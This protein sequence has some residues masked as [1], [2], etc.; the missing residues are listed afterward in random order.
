MTLISG[1]AS[2]AN[3]VF[4]I[5][6]ALYELQPT[7]QAWI[8][9]DSSQR[10]Y[11]INKGMVTGTNWNGGDDV[12]RYL[13]AGKS[14]TYSSGQ[15]FNGPKI[16]W[17][18]IDGQ[19]NSG[20]NCE[21]DSNGRRSDTPIPF[22]FN[23]NFGGTE[24]SGAYLIP[25]GAMV[26]GPDRF[27]YATSA[28]NSVISLK[29]SGIAAFGADLKAH[30]FASD[31]GNSTY[32]WT[33][34][35]TINGQQ[36]FVATWE[37]IR[38]WND[39]NRQYSFQTVLIN[40]GSGNFE[41]WFN[42]EKIDPDI[43]GYQAP[44]IF[45]NLVDGKVSDNEFKIYSSTGFTIGKCEIINVNTSPTMYGNLFPARLADFS[46][47][48]AVG[49]VVSSLKVTNDNSVLFFQDDACTSPISS[50]TFNG[51]KYLQAYLNTG[52]AGVHAGWYVWNATDTENIK[53]EI[54]E[55]F[56]NELTS[57]LI[58]GGEKALISNS[59]NSDVLGRY[60]LGMRN[61]STT[62]DANLDSSLGRE[63]TSVTEPPAQE[64]PVVLNNPVV[65]PVAST[66][67]VKKEFRFT[68]GSSVLSNNNKKTLRSLAQLYVPG[69]KFSIT[70]SAGQTKGVPTRKVKK[71]AENRA[72]RV[73]KYLLA[74]GVKDAD[75]MLNIE[76]I[77]IRVTPKLKMIINKL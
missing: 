71:L 22:G 54:T 46:N 70:G 75:I 74:Q 42:Y 17:T 66:N 64:N 40:K 24:Y 55:F 48:V 62:G 31:P 44:E 4:P 19:V 77:S 73:K 20:L 28:S 1:T 13:P 65:T 56:P 57:K 37:R 21:T 8:D 14:C 7:G 50:T 6:P 67:E 38:S 53:I 35:T 45:S 30:T 12:M 51:Y 16:Y 10:T 5:D 23:I 11:L 32:V 61:G 33:A 43:S 2:T 34:Q 60:I 3:P 18:N 27:T 49:T 39:S 52:Y 47:R 69:Y 63:S 9:V 41:T 25:A 36:A 29:N 76:I 68:A 26:F 15:T 58:D 59:L 72:L